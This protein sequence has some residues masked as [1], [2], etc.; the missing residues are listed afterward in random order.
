MS[1]YVTLRLA[2]AL[3][4]VGALSIGYFRLGAQQTPQAPPSLTIER[5]KED[6][7][8]I[9]GDGGNVGRAVNEGRRHSGG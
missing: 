5:V 4:M 3:G 2:L 7:F 6:L 9:V 1:R 8:N